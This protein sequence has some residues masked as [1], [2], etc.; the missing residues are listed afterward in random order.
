MSKTMNR[1]SP[2][3]RE[4]SLRLRFDTER[5]HSSRWQAEV[6]ISATV[7][8]TAQTPNEWV[9]KAEAHSGRRASIP[10]EMAERIKALERVNREL[11]QTNEILR[12]ASAYSA[13]A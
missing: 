7:G 5:Q 3:V 10:T 1:L 13:M 6:S 12:K 11:R 8:C 4:R 9:N 2:E